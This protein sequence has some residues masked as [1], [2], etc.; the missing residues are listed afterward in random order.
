VRFI[1]AEIV[2][3]SVSEGDKTCCLA[4]ASGFDGAI[5]AVQ[6]DGVNN[7]GLAILCSL[8]RENLA[9]FQFQALDDH[10]A[11]GRKIANFVGN[12]GFFGDCGLS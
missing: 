2:T 5:R 10:L 7:L 12:D 11:A 1:H 8:C 4:Y 3:R 9:F 6:A